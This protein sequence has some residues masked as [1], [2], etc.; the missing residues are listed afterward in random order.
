MLGQVLLP[1]D[2]VRQLTVRDYTVMR[3][4]RHIRCV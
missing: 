2:G 4:D 3:V 1:S